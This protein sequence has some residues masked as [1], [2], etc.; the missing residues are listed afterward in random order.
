LTRTP[1]RRI[2]S[3]GA[4]A[5]RPNDV[6]MI[7]RV[8]GASWAS[9]AAAA[10]PS[11]PGHL[12]V[13]QG[14]VAAGVQRGGDHLVA[15]SDLATTSKSSSR[16][17]SA[18][19][20]ERTIAWSSREAGDHA[21]I[22]VASSPEPRRALGRGGSWG[23][24]G[25]WGGRELGRAGAGVG[26]GLTQPARRTRSANPRTSGAERHGASGGLDPFAQAGQPVPDPATPPRPSSTISIQSRS[27]RIVQCAPGRAHPR[28]VMPSRSPSR[29][30]RTR[31]VT[32]SPIPASSAT[33]PAARRLRG[34]WPARRRA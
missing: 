34:T 16:A 26:A 21:D 10:S 27:T 12:D 11:M 6:R 4:V 24:A 31:R 5:G 33:M 8:D 32:M 30:A 29:T 17:S 13:E 3:R 25:S 23:R 1:A 20:A 18:A 15:P 9:A 7:T 28:L 2:P 19:S 22:V 14:D